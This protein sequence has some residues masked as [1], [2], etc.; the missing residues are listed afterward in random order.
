M[1]EVLA[2]RKV[3]DVCMGC[4]FVTYLDDD[5]CHTCTVESRDRDGSPY[6]HRVRGT[7]KKR[8][9]KKEDYTEAE[10]ED[11]RFALSRGMKV[12]PKRIYETPTKPTKQNKKE[13]EE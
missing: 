7:Y 5:I 13:R 9:D 6:R 4:G 8:A 10:L 11:L 1:N 2:V 3:R 12:I